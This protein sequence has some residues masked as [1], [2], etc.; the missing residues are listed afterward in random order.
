[1]KFEIIKRN[2]DNSMIA[3]VV[4]KTCYTDIDNTTYWET[5]ALMKSKGL[6]IVPVEDL[7]KKLKDLKK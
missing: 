6:K 7:E 3:I 5:M 2:G 4:K 1:M